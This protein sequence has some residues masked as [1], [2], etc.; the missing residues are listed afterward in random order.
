LL[1]WIPR[2]QWLASKM[3]KQHKGI[4][5]TNPKFLINSYEST[6]FFPSPDKSGP[7]FN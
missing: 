2:R 3:P 4:N 7:D 1:I 5:Q 6:M